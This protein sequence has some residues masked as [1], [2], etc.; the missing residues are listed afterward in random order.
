MERHQLAEMFLS[1]AGKA[2]TALDVGRQK[3]VGGD[4]EEAGPALAES[5]GNLRDA[6][7]VKRERAAV[8][9]VKANRSVDVFPQ[10]FESDGG[11]G[12]QG[13]KILIHVQH[14]ATRVQALQFGISVVG[15]AFG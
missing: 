1:A 4:I 15:Q 11:V 14:W 3:R 12:G 6:E 2:G 13:L 8:G 5:S 7:I 9:F 10:L